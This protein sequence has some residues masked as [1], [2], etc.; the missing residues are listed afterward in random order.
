MLFLRNDA[1]EAAWRVVDPV[2]Q[3]WEAERPAD[4][5]NYPAGAWGPAAADRLIAESGAA[6][7]NPGSAEA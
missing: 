5:P 1:T 3:Q 4:F 2:I 7:R 6:W